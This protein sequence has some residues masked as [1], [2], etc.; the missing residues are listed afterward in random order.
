MK[1][2]ENGGVPFTRP[3]EDTY[4]YKIPARNPVHG[5][6]ETVGDYYV[7]FSGSYADL[8]RTPT[9]PEVLLNFKDKTEI[10][11]NSISGLE[12]KMTGPGVDINGRFIKQT[13]S[14]Y[15]FDYY[16]GNLDIDES[17]YNDREIRFPS[18]LI[19][20]NQG[21]TP[22][23]FHIDVWK[24]GT[25][26]IKNTYDQL[27]DDGAT[28]DELQLCEDRMQEVIIKQNQTLVETKGLAYDFDDYNPGTNRMFVYFDSYTK[29]FN[30]G[31]NGDYTK[32][33]TAIGLFFDNYTF[34]TDSQYKIE[35]KYSI[36][37]KYKL[38]GEPIVVDGKELYRIQAVKNFGD[39][40][41][42]QIGGF[43]ES[44]ENLSHQGTCWIYDDAK[45]MD[46][47]QI[48][49]D[50]KVYGTS[51]VC[52]DA[53][54]MGN[55][56]VGF[57]GY[58]LTPY[59]NPENIKHFNSISNWQ[60]FGTPLLDYYEDTNLW[61]AN[62]THDSDIN[63]IYRERMGRFRN[64]STDI[65]I[66][67]KAIIRDTAK[68]WVD[69]RISGSA[70][71]MENAIVGSFIE[72]DTSIHPHA[73]WDKWEKNI[74]WN[75]ASSGEQGG[76][77]DFGSGRYYGYDETNT[78]YTDVTDSS[79]IAGNAYVRGKFLGATVVKGTSYIQKGYI[80]Q[81]K[82]T[83]DGSA[84]FLSGQWSTLIN[85]NV[86]INCTNFRSLNSTYVDTII[87]AT[88]FTAFSTTMRSTYILGNTY[89]LGDNISWSEYEQY[90]EDEDNPPYM[91]LQ[92]TVTRCKFLEG[93]SFTFATG[94]SSY[95]PQLIDCIIE[96][97]N[98]LSL[99]TITV[100]DVHKDLLGVST[101]ESGA[102][103]MY[104]SVYS[105][106]QYII[107]KQR[108]N[109]IAG[110]RFKNNV[111]TTAIKYLI[112]FRDSLRM[113]WVNRETGHTLSWINYSPNTVYR[114]VATENFGSITKGTTGGY[115]EHQ[116]NLSIFNECWIY[117][118]SCVC[119][120]AM[121]TDDA[122]VSNNTWI[123]GDVIV[124]DSSSVSSSSLIGG[125]TYP[126]AN[127][128]GFGM[129]ASSIYIR[130]VAQITNAILSGN[131][132]VADNAKISGKNNKWKTFL[133]TGNGISWTTPR[134]GSII[135]RDYSEISGVV[136]IQS[137]VLLEMHNMSKIKSPNAFL[138]IVQDMEMYLYDYALIENTTVVA[139][140]T[141][142][143]RSRFGEDAY[144]TIYNGMSGL[145]NPYTTYRS[146][147]S[148]GKRYIAMYHNS[149]LY[150]DKSNFCKEYQINMSGAASMSLTGALIAYSS[151]EMNQGSGLTL[152]GK[153][154][155]AA[156]PGKEN[157]T[158]DGSIQ[159]LAS[160]IIMNDNS[161][162][163][164]DANS[165][166][167][168]KDKNNTMLVTDMMIQG[169]DLIMNH[170]SI[171]TNS[172]YYHTFL[173]TPEGEG[174]GD[175][176]TYYDAHTGIGS[177]IQFGENGILGASYSTGLENCY[178]PS[179][180]MNQNSTMIGKYMPAVSYQNV[181]NY[182]K[183]NVG[184][185]D[186]NLLKTKLVTLN[187]FGSINLD[188]WTDF[189][190]ANNGYAIELPMQYFI[191]D[192]NESI[193]G[194]KVKGF[195]ESAFNKTVPVR[196]GEEV[197]LIYN[198]G[199]YDLQTDAQGQPKYFLSKLPA[200]K[201]EYE[202]PYET[203]SAR[204]KYDL[205]FQNYKKNFRKINIKAIGE[206]YTMYYKPFSSDPYDETD[207]ENTQ[208]LN[209]KADLPNSFY[210]HYSQMA[211][212][213]ITTGS[214]S[215]NNR[216]PTIYLM[217]TYIRYMN[218]SKHDNVNVSGTE[219]ENSRILI[220]NTYMNGAGSDQTR[221]VNAYYPKDMITA[222]KYMQNYNVN[223]PTRR[224]DPSEIKPI[225]KNFCFGTNGYQNNYH[226]SN[227]EELD[228]NIIFEPSPLYD[229]Y[230]KSSLYKYDTCRQYI[231]NPIRVIKGSNVD[232]SQLESITSLDYRTYRN[233]FFYLHA[234]L[235]STATFN[236]NITSVPI[237][238]ST[239]QPGSIWK[240]S[241]D[242][243]SKTIIDGIIRNS[244]I[245]IITMSNIN[246]LLY[247]ATLDFAYPI[248]LGHTGRTIEKDF[249]M[250]TKR[251]IINSSTLSLSTD[252]TKY[253]NIAVNRYLPP[254][255]TTFEIEPDIAI[256]TDTNKI[257][258]IGRML[259]IPLILGTFL[260]DGSTN[261]SLNA[262][263]ENHSTIWMSDKYYPSTIPTFTST[264]EVLHNTYRHYLSEYNSDY[265]K[266]WTLMMSTIRKYEWY[267]SNN[268][269]GLTIGLLHDGF[270]TMGNTSAGYCPVRAL[271]PFDLKETPNSLELITSTGEIGTIKAV[272]YSATLSRFGT[273]DK[274]YSN[275]NNAGTDGYG[276]KRMFQYER[277]QGYLKYAAMTMSY[278]YGPIRQ[279]IFSQGVIWSYRYPLVDVK[280][281]GDPVY[282]H[283]YKP[284]AE[285]LLDNTSIAYT[286]M[287]KYR[288]IADS[289]YPGIATGSSKT[290]K[291]L[292]RYAHINHRMM[293]RH[294]GSSMSHLLS[295]YY[296]NKKYPLYGKLGYDYNYNGV[297]KVVSLSYNHLENKY[298]NDNAN[299]FNDPM[300]NKF[301]LFLHQDATP[302][303][304]GGNSTNPWAYFDVSHTGIPT[305]LDLIATEARNVYGET[306]IKQFFK[307]N[308]MNFTYGHQGA[309]LT[310]DLSSLSS[311]NPT[312][313]TYKT[314]L[315]GIRNLNYNYIAKW[316]V[317]GSQ[318]LGLNIV[319][320]F[321][322]RTSLPYGYTF[323]HLTAGEEEGETAGLD[324]PLVQ[325][326]GS[327]DETTNYLFVNKF[328]ADRETNGTMTQLS[329]TL[330]DNNNT[331]G[332][333]FTPQNVITQSTLNPVFYYYGMNTE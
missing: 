27:I 216:F 271:S 23:R 239:N 281:Y 212:T 248:N 16:S 328:I 129:S 191:P 108:F 287:D 28:N 306:S 327:V 115:V 86:N 169:L 11:G 183:N 91:S 149:T 173:A 205:R 213:D 185:V 96:G 201:E 285:S 150:M 88:T 42:D 269:E 262:L 122:T 265:R 21:S 52:D 233:N 136:R 175:A 22:I 186:Q 264:I 292:Q 3:P 124:S 128:L 209:I 257:S 19:P 188:P 53:T 131:I 81:G 236:F 210:S 160:N 43:V 196:N 237:D 261:M 46:S 272:Y 316:K 99:D 268:N 137:S 67:D 112:D 93:S 156:T 63:G 263:L 211:R 304:L 231:P 215:V 71:V 30:E 277:G 50:A 235:V 230:S 177:V 251:P 152:Y 47:S 313:A 276:I 13:D 105:E 242:T 301:N 166:Q 123:Y 10:L 323:K 258:Q 34:V 182:I 170:G 303:T 260:I 217:D 139:E 25:Q 145:N 73:K 249:R 330:K 103:T 69:T 195:I 294:K 144:S 289:N 225:Y 240:S 252:A 298:L 232:I 162:M 17:N 126:K 167:V 92:A 194:R 61:A 193:Q 72:F 300:Y 57:P 68:V 247:Q 64:I 83:I 218:I 31:N 75:G 321:V 307:Y 20:Y 200:D 253:A 111:L 198:I 290:T 55:A 244:V 319:N 2:F 315:S 180:V 121:V 84:I 29:N 178:M 100:D 320:K 6:Y 208:K 203:M 58:I 207:T 299:L 66:S 329:G 140:P 157:Y 5:D 119:D 314:S 204:G 74:I 14:L 174:D 168:Y 101:T 172:L 130:G 241:Y 125:W 159:I 143:S 220:S 202:K 12:S 78:K 40:V 76:D 284:G 138:D 33:I 133:A 309:N 110:A 266:D 229:K 60:P 90:L 312:F 279:P 36:N 282:I 87:N 39:V 98:V 146:T 238:K 127:R 70:I 62:Q 259:N 97:S 32:A 295:D 45:A 333:V 109:V 221:F 158:G 190:T 270:E 44:E 18:F 254:A 326:T 171:W 9:D 189:D 317:D 155:L 302:T 224:F 219:I 179:I 142:N 227:Y 288:N 324:E 275:S 38:I 278:Y 132:T 246:A 7:L 228:Y 89:L 15:P 245:K 234:P 322:T 85:T 107:N 181:I 226:N 197:A 113:N 82:N 331:Q 48:I 116:G 325:F 77:Q 4:N 135:L 280:L 102:N 104:N 154:S 134:L 153:Q 311:Q 141:E 296:R 147:P 51:I 151:L 283:G 117:D 187:I 256:D 206:F 165:T 267:T 148:G 305:R 26:I 332:V 273:Y 79:I 65:I 1:E 80:F 223:P 310:M 176:S 214:N 120:D 161:S 24:N 293:E 308:V 243:S 59:N 41:I 199:S 297:L 37:R 106:F 163:H 274:G 222:K 114:I 8:K 94:T 118:T 250:F 318:T 95:G 286:L 56:T 184:T 255:G 164:V 49:E 192:I 54:I 35:I 291:N